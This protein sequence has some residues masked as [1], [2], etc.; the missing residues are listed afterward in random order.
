MEHFQAEGRTVIEAWAPPGMDWN[1]VRQA[2][3]KQRFGSEG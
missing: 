1:D 3:L 2:C